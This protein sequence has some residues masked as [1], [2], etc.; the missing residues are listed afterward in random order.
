[1]SRLPKPRPEH[2]PAG[3]TPILVWVVYALG[4]L[5]LAVFVFSGLF[6]LGAYIASDDVPVT[7]DVSALAVVLWGGLLALAAVTFLR[8]RRRR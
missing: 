8:R 6:L 5:A 4:I 2:E 1:M 3:G 7:Y